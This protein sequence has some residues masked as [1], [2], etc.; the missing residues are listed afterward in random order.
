MLQLCNES[1]RFSFYFLL[2][3]LRIRFYDSFFLL[4]YLRIS[5]YGQFQFKN[6]SEIMYPFR[7]F[8]GSLTRHSSTRRNWNMCA[9]SGF[10][11]H[12]PSV[13]VVKTNA[14]VEAPTTIGL[15][16]PSIW[17]FPLSKSISIL[18]LKHVGPAIHFPTQKRKREERQWPVLL[19]PDRQ[20]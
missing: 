12:D 15:T 5:F 7:H 17:I 14:F 19:P 3:H 4:H 8:V 13:S 2:H 1:H 11:T 18:L 9:S 20:R 16:C 6:T 10:Q